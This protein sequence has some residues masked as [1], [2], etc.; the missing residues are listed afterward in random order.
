MIIAF[1]PGA[2]GNRYLQ[3]LQGRAWTR[4]KV[5]YDNTNPG[6]ILS[7]RYLLGSVPAA[8]T[9]YTLTHC[10]N[11]NKIVNTL[12]DSDTVFIHSDLQQSL[13]REWMLHGHQHFLEK[14]VNHSVSRLEHYCA[15]QEPAWPK[16]NRVDQLD[17]LPQKILQ[18]VNADYEKITNRAN[19]A[20]SLLAQLT[21]QYIDQINSAYEII[22]WH[23]EYYQQWPM[24]VSN[25][26]TVVNINTDND[27]FS[28]FMRQELSLYCSE[29]FD[30]VWEHIYN[31]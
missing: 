11:Y 16:I 13:R 26:T 30:S 14:Q 4:P 6:Q 25:A 20:P 9:N 5:S 29:V 15:F 17:N 31:D 23:K 22:S 21:Q 8:T 7:L 27:E 19:D 3:M 28:T 10:M 12:H 24:D 1:Y 18:E 2:G